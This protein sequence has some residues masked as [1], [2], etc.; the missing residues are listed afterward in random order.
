MTDKDKDVRKHITIL[1]KALRV[2]KVALDETLPNDCYAVEV[3]NDALGYLRKHL[4]E[5][6]GLL[7]PK[8]L[9]FVWVYDFPMFDYDEKEA[10]HAAVHH[11]FTAPLAQDIPLLETEPHKVKTQAYDLVLNGHEIGGGSIRIHDSKMQ[12]QVLKI[13]NISDQ[14]AE[15]KF[16]FLLKALEFGTPPHGGI[17]FG[18]D[19]IIMLMAGAD[20]IRDVIA[21]PKTQKGICNLSE[22]PSSV[23]STQL[24]ELGVKTVKL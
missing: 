24:L 11:P 18:L 15:E 4:G 22:A 23:S 12:A 10:R 3:V 6:L 7:D 2:A 8:Q 13:L 5:K 1:R 21:F 19:R 17:A 9:A 20:S 14:E 16:G